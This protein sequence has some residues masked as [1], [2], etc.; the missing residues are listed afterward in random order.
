MCHIKLLLEA[1][2]TLYAHMTH[3]MNQAWPQNEETHRCRTHCGNALAPR[4]DRCGTPFTDRDELISHMLNTHSPVLVVPTSSKTF[5]KA[6]HLTATIT[7]REIE[8]AAWN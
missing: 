1:R 8:R 4:M 6:Y 7:R 2:H 3:H 5:E